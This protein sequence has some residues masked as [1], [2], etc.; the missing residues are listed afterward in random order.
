MTATR[1]TTLGRAA[2]VLKE[3]RT[4]VSAEVGDGISVLVT[5]TRNLEH[6]LNPIVECTHIRANDL[7]RTLVCLH[8]ERHRTVKLD[9]HE[10]GESTLG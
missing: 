4:K 6:R 9:T 1:S 3:A 7:P 5:Y 10:E 2:G 8:R